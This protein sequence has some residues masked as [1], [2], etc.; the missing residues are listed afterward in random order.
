MKKIIR[1]F[2]LSALT[3]GIFSSV[4]AQR[5]RDSRGG[6]GGNT[7]FSRSSSPSRSFSAPQRS[8]S[9]RSAPQRSFDQRQQR[10][11]PQ[12]STPERAVT[13]NRNGFTPNNANVNRN[14][15]RGNGTAITPQRN[16]TAYNTRV[17]SAT[18]NNY[19]GTGN[20]SSYNYNNRGN[21]IY[22]SY[23]GNVYGHRT[24]FMYGPRYAV[25]PRSFISINFG[26]YPYYYNNGLYYGYYN[27]YYQSMFPPFGLSIGMLPFG[28]SSLFLG[29]Y[30]YYY[31]NGIY[32]R[33]QGDNSYQVV[34]APMGATVSSLPGGARSVVVNGETLYELNGTYYKASQ[35]SNGNNVFTVVGKN[36]V[37]NN[38]PNVQNDNSTAPD[39]YNQSQ[40]PDNTAPSLSSLNIGDTVGQLPDGSKLVTINGEK[41]YETPDNVYLKGESNDGVVQ[42]K[43]VGK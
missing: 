26:G 21:N 2:F 12:R 3:A 9:Q 17:T 5:G 27:G 10:V 34:D 43:V 28:Y 38:T 19:N 22:H 35:D 37:I 16:T 7:Q 25:I 13:N 11:S 1:L 6:G 29:G 24:V 31:Y 14:A 42:F 36:G 8:M 18:R 40:A 33:P 23:Y 20:R 39:S 30:P 4:Q 15:Y 32:Y 41:L